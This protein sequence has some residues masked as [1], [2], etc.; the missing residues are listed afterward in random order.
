MFPAQPARASPHPRLSDAL[1][2]HQ[3]PL[4]IYHH[5]RITPRRL[6]TPR[7]RHLPFG[8]L[9][10]ARVKIWVDHVSNKIIPAWHKLPCTSS[11]PYSLDDA[12]NEFN[13]QLRAWVREAAPLAEGPWWLGKEFSMAD[14]AFAPRVL[15]HWVLGHFGK[16]PHIPE[17]GEGGEDEEVWARWRI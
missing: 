9:P 17:K 3:A 14:I 6:S 2:L 12:R 4:R 5:M 7:T 15:R 1:R 10:K 16:D 8:D 13:T 11:S